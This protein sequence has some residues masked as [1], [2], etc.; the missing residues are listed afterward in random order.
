M[1]VKTLAFE[2]RPVNQ[3]QSV[4]SLDLPNTFSQKFSQPEGNFTKIIEER[5]RAR[6]GNPPVTNRPKSKTKKVLGSGIS[7]EDIQR[8]IKEFNK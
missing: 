4:N 8:I 6:A 5:L 7:E 1:N 3:G 2:V